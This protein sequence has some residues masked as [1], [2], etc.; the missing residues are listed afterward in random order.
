MGIGVFVLSSGL[1]QVSE[2]RD[3]DHDCFPQGWENRF[4]AW[5]DPAKFWRAQPSLIQAE[6]VAAIRAYQLHI[7][8]QRYE[9]AIAPLEAAKRELKRKA[10]QE[11]LVILGKTPEMKEEAEAEEL[12]NQLAIQ[13]QE[14][15]RSVRAA[16]NQAQ[17][18]MLASS[19]SWGEKCTAYSQNELKK[20]AH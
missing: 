14:I 18:D 19:L 17:K 20:L 11:F 4:R 6:V 3:L 10:N 9:D 1:S 8:E 7:A 2:A 16:E 13:D 12:R 15:E 5:R